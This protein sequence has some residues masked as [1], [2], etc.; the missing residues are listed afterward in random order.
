MKEDKTMKE[1]SLQRF[2]TNQNTLNNVQKS[3][4]RIYK[5]NERTKTPNQ[6]NCTLVEQK[7]Q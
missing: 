2:Q 3:L 6:R 7:C 4:G 1:V 5:T